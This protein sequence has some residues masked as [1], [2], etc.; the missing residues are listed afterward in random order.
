MDFCHNTISDGRIGIVESPTRTGKTMSMLCA[1]LTW[2]TRGE[3]EMPS[4][5]SKRVEGISWIEKKVSKGSSAEYTVS[6]AHRLAPEKYRPKIFYCTRTHS[7]ISEVVV[8]FKKTAFG[9]HVRCL[10]LSSRRKLCI[11]AAVLKSADVNDA[12]TALLESDSRC[13][14]FRAELFDSHSEFF[15]DNIGRESWSS[16]VVY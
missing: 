12:C 15:I 13:P 11:N 3:D 5:P 9:S 6:K 16:V 4:V 1:S 2:L 10:V 8:E 14:Y 7:Q